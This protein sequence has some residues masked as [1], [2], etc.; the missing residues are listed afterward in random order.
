MVHP[1]VYA[2]QNRKSSLLL[3]K[4][5]AVSGNNKNDHTLFS[6]YH[7]VNKQ[8]FVSDILLHLTES[9]S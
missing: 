9:I 5:D 4:V 1:K 6:M 2:R 3:P 8:L 7:R